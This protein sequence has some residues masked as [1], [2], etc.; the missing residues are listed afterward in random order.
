M[1]LFA[2]SRDGRMMLL[3]SDQLGR[4]LLSRMLHGGRTSLAV[5][6]L[7][8]LVGVTIGTLL[9]ITSAYF[10]GVV[11]LMVQRVVDALIVLPG[12]VLAITIMAVFGFSMTVVI[13]AIA[14]N[15]IGGVSRVVRSRALSLS[16]AQYVEGARAVGA[17][18]FRIILH[19]LVPNSISVSI[20]LFAV[21]IGSAVIAEAGLSFLG[22]G[23]Q[24]P[25]PSWGNMLTNAQTHFNQGPH[26]AVIPGL[27]IVV[28]VLSINLFGDALRDAIDPRLRGRR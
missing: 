5:G 11:D 22:L 27:T 16:Q 24:P 13:L 15:M 17:S 23:I 18:N 7:A 1:P 4:D 9:G 21:G 14:V 19:H 26:V 25:T 10:G 20:V 8:P 28:V 3:G 12:L 6:I 2:E